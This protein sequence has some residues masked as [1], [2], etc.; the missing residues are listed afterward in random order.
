MGKE[1][2]INILDKIL[3][4]AFYVLITAVTFSTALVEVA[5]SVIII[6]YFLRKITRKDFAF[7]RYLFLVAFGLFALWNLF[8]FYNSNYF[9]E[10]IRGLIKVV[11]YGLLL[12]ITIDTFKARR[13]L[14]K[15][16][17]VLIFWSLVIAL[18][19]IVQHILGFGVMRLRTIDALDYLHRISSSFRHA[20]NFGAYL[21][22]IMPIYLSFIFCKKIKRRNKICFSLGLT[23]LIFC[24]IRTYSRG[25]WLAL[26]VAMLIL[27]L[28]KSRKIFVALIV[29]IVILT[30]FLPHRIKSRA[31]DSLNFQE[32]T[33]WERLKLW[34][35]ALLMVKE[36]PFLGFGVNTYTKN[37][38][39]YKPPDYW[40]VIYPHNSYL[41]MATEIGLV[42]LGLF[43]TFIILAFIYA[44]SCFKLMPGGWI[45]SA[46]KGLFVGLLGFLIHSAVDTHLYS[47]NLVIM[48]YL[49]LGLCIALCNYVRANPA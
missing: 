46:A 5:V 21:V 38:P 19:G 16:I 11:K 20:N 15:A 23:P 24:I 13:M 3:E 26:F 49:L 28:L 6:C 35:G 41:H 27:A 1:K 40:G 36:H 10:S 39:D 48:F 33:S 37:F 9:Y 4:W 34:N 45:A 42:G 8:S 44:S 18:N 47:V 25:A 29:L 31:S 43:L 17:Y 2:I 14:K 22:M 30:L 12:V 7:P 32:G